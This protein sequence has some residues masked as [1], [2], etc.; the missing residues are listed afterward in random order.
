MLR[1]TRVAYL[2]ALA[3][4]GAWGLGLPSGVRAQATPL[5]P[6]G[7]AAYRDV[8]LFADR[9]LV[10]R[11]FLTARRPLSRLT[12]AKLLREARS[13]AQAR[14]G[15]VPVR[16]EEALGRLA[17]RFAEELAL[18]EAP[19]GEGDVAEARRP[20][21]WAAVEATY[22]D[23]P[24]RPIHTQF[25]GD[26]DY[27]DADLNPLL[28]DNQGRWLAD[29]ATAAVELLLD[30]RLGPHVAAHVS[31]RVAVGRERGGS[32]EADFSLLT[33]SLRATWGNLAID[34]GRNHLTH[35]H[36]GPFAPTLSDGPR[37]LDMLRFSM[38]EPRRLPWVLRHIGPVF[39]SAAVADM[40]RDRD[41]PGSKL[42][43]FQGVSHPHA[44]LELTAA[45]LNHQLG[46]GAPDASWKD[47]IL[48][49]LMMESRRLLPTTGV[50]PISDKTLT[51]GASLRLPSMGTTLYTEVMTTDDHNL[52]SELDAG[53][54]HNAAWVLGLRA[55]GAGEEGRTDVWF[56]AGRTG[57]RPYTHHQFSSGLTV[58]R[59]VLG[60]AL[61]PLGTGARGGIQWNG[62]AQRIAVEGALER[63]QGDTY[64][65]DN[66]R[67]HTFRKEED[68]PD[69]I[70]IRTTVTWT[71][72][73]DITGLRTTL[74]V[75]YERVRRFDFTDESRNNVM[76][77]VRLE[78]AW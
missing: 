9:G 14:D 61:G 31:P 63:Y 53:L 25:D 43:V 40:G 11:E 57:V 26:A 68:N 71:R 45:V 59:R 46:E 1:R 29:G 75:G 8:E 2:M 27:I 52:F 39:V 56:E 41:T 34:L 65:Y 77:Q 64:S 17:A 13:R 47:R 73:P 7:D 5:V 18:L 28:Q 69:E 55:R 58:N 15:A 36:A 62:S 74:R 12:F 22:A 30:G 32:G 67:V 48:D 16:V 19:E 10:D 72:H 21:R 20:L 78:Y 4:L 66:R 35:G 44:N 33:G 51:V 42:F 38:E 24:S 76:A 23:S 50:P 3:V 54:W 6:I 70:R 49:I 60:S 37:G